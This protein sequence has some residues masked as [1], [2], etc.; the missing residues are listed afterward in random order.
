MGYNVGMTTQELT[1]M[2]NQLTKAERKKL[3]DYARE[4]IAVRKAPKMKV[5]TTKDFIEFAKITDKEVAQGKTISSA[6]V[7]ADLRGK[8][9]GISA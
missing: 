8:R 9:R 6:T 1:M 7:L 3:G 4:L 2:I 5:Y